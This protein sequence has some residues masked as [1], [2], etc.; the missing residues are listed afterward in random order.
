MQISAVLFQEDGWWV[1]QC[2]QYDIAAQAK[3]LPQLHSE[4][5]RALVGHAVACL[6]EGLQ[7]FDCLDPAPQ[8]YWVMFGEA[9]LHVTGPDFPP[10]RAPTAV[11]NLPSLDLRV[12]AYV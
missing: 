8:K 5:A 12:P 4:M 2:L 10:F 11:D 1:G 7:P 3:T 9:A 6:T